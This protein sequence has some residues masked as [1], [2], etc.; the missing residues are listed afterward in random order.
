MGLISSMPESPT[1]PNSPVSPP[2]K[3][4]NPVIIAYLRNHLKNGKITDE[5]FKDIDCWIKVLGEETHCSSCK[6][7]LPPMDWQCCDLCS[8]VVCDRCDICAE[9]CITNECNE[10]D[11]CPGCGAADV[12]GICRDCRQ[13]A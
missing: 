9:C 5:L 3:T 10:A 11:K 1:P 6:N 13:E 4:L 12:G 2:V 7:R 8:S